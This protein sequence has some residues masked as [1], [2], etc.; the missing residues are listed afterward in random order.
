MKNRF[1]Q[2]LTWLEN[3]F[4]GKVGCSVIILLLIYLLLRIITDVP[5][6]PIAA[7]VVYI[8]KKVAQVLKDSSVITRELSTKLSPDMVSPDML[9]KTPS[10]NINVEI[11]KMG[12]LFTLT[13]IILGYYAR[14]F[15][16]KLLDQLPC[17]DLLIEIYRNYKSNNSKRLI[18][19]R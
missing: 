8:C 16:Y 7:M 17:G 1:D 18:P 19:A 5:R 11:T 14:A 9:N 13:L 12:I 3:V 6:I 15:P 2:F 10:S 4:G